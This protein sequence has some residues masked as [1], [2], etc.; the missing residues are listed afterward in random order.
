MRISAERAAPTAEAGPAPTSEGFVIAED[1]IERVRVL[2]PRTDGGR[3]GAPTLRSVPGGRI[4]AGGGAAVQIA[5]PEPVRVSE[6]ARVSEDTSATDRLFARI[7]SGRAADVDAARQLLAPPEA[8]IEVPGEGVPGSWPEGDDEG[9]QLRRSD[10]DEAVLQQRDRLIG[11]LEGTLAKKLKRA[12]QDEQ[13]ELL[14]RLRG[15]RGAPK[16]ATLLPDGAEHAARIASVAR[17]LLDEARRAGADLAG[18]S[19]RPVGADDEVADEL[20]T[21]LITPLRRRLT[22]AVRESAGDDQAVLV[23][24]IGTVYREWKTQRVEPAVVDAVASAFARGSFAAFPEGT[25][26]RWVVEDTDGPCPDCD[27]NALAGYL[28]RG[29]VFPTGQLH[30]PAHAGCRCLLAPAE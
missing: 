16:A 24:A 9:L 21:A 3:S 23:E 10:E 13:N 11:D 29:E 1:G 26:L 12:L 30:P 18:S 27:D 19:G 20:A 14:D 5:E 22:D 17:A 15:L 25:L 2:R 6:P 7:R 8:P 28:P 4:A